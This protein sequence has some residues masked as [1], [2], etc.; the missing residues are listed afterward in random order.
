[1]H[2][3]VVLSL[4]SAGSV[5]VEIRPDAP[6]VEEGVLLAQS[7][8]DAPNPGGGRV[9][10]SRASAQELLVRTVWA[11]GQS[12]ERRV[13]A[14]P[15]ECAAVRRVLSTLIRAWLA[16]PP[17]TRAA[18]GETARRAEDSGDVGR[19]P[20]STHAP[21]RGAEA[22]TTT[23]PTTTAPS[24]TAP[25]TTAASTTAASTTA[26]VATAPKADA[27]PTSAPAAPEVG[28][29]ATRETI[30][31]TEPAT[32]A[33]APAV[34]QPV[35][36]SVDRPA[37]SV[38]ADPEIPSSSKPAAGWRIGLGA[39]GGTTAVTTPEL[40][41]AGSF[42]LE[43]G[44]GRLGFGLEGGLE[45]ARTA[46]IAGR[47]HAWAMQRWLTLYGKLAVPVSSRVALAATLGIRGW[48]IEAGANGFTTT[49][50]ASRFDV[51][52]A[53]TVGAEV[54]LGSLVL[55]IRGLGAG[56]ILEDRVTVEGVGTVLFL[57]RWQVG[58]LI[59]LGWN[60][61]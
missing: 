17:G 13:P 41:A 44:K 6:C 18:T 5:W 29:T 35:A 28:A 37:A 31:A 12:I 47:G 61:P 39:L 34:A 24:T 14:S 27:G 51:G 21:S 7:L 54:A 11:D 60:F 23:A 38:A 57:K 4:L 49:S 40:V 53:L 33:R 43:A 1:M 10:V 50:S 56:R 36:A 15:A 25:S 32:G 45:S 3:S 48:Q 22:P 46:S 16:S 42:F 8:K 26:P 30:G 55:L 19:A 59:G 2:A 20:A 9:V 58:A 52:A